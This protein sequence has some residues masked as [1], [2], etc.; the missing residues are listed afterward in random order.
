M[1]GSRQEERQ[2][3]AY[4]FTQD[5]L[6][7]RECNETGANNH[8]GGNTETSTDIQGIGIRK[9]EKVQG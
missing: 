7:T 1:E 6:G 9:S 2:D 8:T 4:T 5:R 3:C